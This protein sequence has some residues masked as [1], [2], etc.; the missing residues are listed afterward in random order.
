MR[1]MGNIACKGT[2]GVR[3]SEFSLEMRQEAESSLLKHPVTVLSKPSSN[4]NVNTTERIKYTVDAANTKVVRA[5]SHFRARLWGPL[6]LF[7]GEY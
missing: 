4:A 3:N 1:R 5:R 2:A 6:V 7:H